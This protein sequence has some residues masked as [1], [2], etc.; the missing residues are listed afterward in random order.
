MSIPPSIIVGSLQDP[1]V[2]AVVAHVPSA[3]VLDVERLREIDFAFDGEVMRTGEFGQDLYTL[4]GSRGWI[5]RLVPPAWQRGVEADSH[6]AAV[7]ASWLSVLANIIRLGPTQWLTPLDEG[8]IAESKL[9]QLRAAK[10]LG[11]MTPKTLIATDP[12]TV[13]AE[14]GP[15]PVVKPLTHGYFFDERGANVVYAQE[16]DVE[17][18]PAELWRTVPM[19]AQER[20]YARRHFRVVTVADR[21]WACELE[22]EGLPVDWRS[23]ES[24]HGA[25]LSVSRPDE[26]L[27]DG[28]RSMSRALGLGYSS[29]DWVMSGPGKYVMLDVNPGGQWLFLPSEVS[30]LV[31]Q[32]VAGWLRGHAWA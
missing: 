9:S 19:L 21:V 11:L 17:E 8:L 30:E 26:R 7:A 5:R 32:A 10:R 22:A 6:Q 4:A 23:V 14:L 29:Q 18:I 31:T 12:T 2:R 20:I 27:L 1:H 25:F 16:V 28:A 13:V 24:S 15:R 3:V